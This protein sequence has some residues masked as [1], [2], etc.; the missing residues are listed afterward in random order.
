MTAP[1]VTPWEIAQ[2]A[3]R[4]YW[5]PGGD[6]SQLAERRARERGFQAWCAGL[7][8]VPDAQPV[9]VLEIGAGPQGLLTRYGASAR[10]KIA[11]E[12]MRLTFADAEAY[13]AKGVERH[14]MSIERWHER[15]LET[16]VDEV[17]MT[18][19][20]QH[21]KHP[22]AVIVIARAH[23][24]R[25]VRLFEWVDEPVSVVHL[26]TIAA[27]DLAFPAPWRLILGTD[28]TATTG[29]YRQRFVARVFERR[30]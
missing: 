19:V 29:D 21:V 30:D 1:A 4:G 15:N 7:L 24:A 14:E 9:S 3:E 6:C 23:A 11:V 20:L 2:E 18:N 5:Y 28:G 26:H 22:E 17:W 27:G 13:A 25:R 12:P 8:G 16:M 10:A